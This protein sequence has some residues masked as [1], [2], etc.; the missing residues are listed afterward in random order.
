[1]ERL[2]CRRPSP[3]SLMGMRDKMCCA[4]E[5]SSDQKERGLRVCVLFYAR[6]RVLIRVT[7][8]TTGKKLHCSHSILLCFFF[9]AFLLLSTLAST[10]DST[11][12]G[13]GNELTLSQAK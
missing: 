1:M 7:P 5:T 12:A 2:G 4:R 8:G 13:H 11:S 3:S 6:I 10:A 9:T